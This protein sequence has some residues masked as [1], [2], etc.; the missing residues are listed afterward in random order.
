MTDARISVVSINHVSGDATNA[1]VC[2]RPH[3]ET[4]NVR[5]VVGRRIGEQKDLASR[6]FSGSV[7]GGGLSQ[8]LSLTM[9]LNAPWRKAT[10]DLVGA[11]GG[12]IR[13]NDDFE[14]GSR[15]VE[16]Q[17]VFQLFG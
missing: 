11:I 2:K 15:A 10:H 5:P 13:S 9:Q 4:K 3:Q 17:R 6:F 14:L 8:S 12:A 7:L 16:R 1:R